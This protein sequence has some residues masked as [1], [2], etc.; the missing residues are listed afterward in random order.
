MKEFFGAVFNALFE[1]ILFLFLV[2]L[3]WLG[4]PAQYLVRVK[5]V[6]TLILLL[7]SEEMLL[8]FHT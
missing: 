8:V 6:D 1:S 3:L 5:K 7:I 2:S 4:I